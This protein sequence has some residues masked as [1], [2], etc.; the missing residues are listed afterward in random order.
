MTCFHNC[1]AKLCLKAKCYQHALRLIEQPMTEVQAGTEAIEILTYNYYRGMLFTG[2]KRFEDAITCLNRVLSLPTRIFHRV[3][4]ES[5][6]KL[7]LLLLIAPQ[8]EARKQQQKNK[9]PPTANSIVRNYVELQ[10]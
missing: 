6:K 1:F 3:H 4:L 2:L 9:L 8:T 5:Y 7:C 10:K